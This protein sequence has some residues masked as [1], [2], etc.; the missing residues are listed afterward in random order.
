M[1]QDTKLAGVPAAVLSGSEDL[2]R[3]FLQALFTADGHVSGATNKGVSARL[4]S[5]SLAL[6]GD[7][8]RML[9]NFGIA[10]RLYANRHLARRVQLPDGR[11]GQ[12]EYECQADHDLVVARDNLARFAQE[13]GFLSS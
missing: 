1:T 4:T 8:Q 7:V 2:Q 5:V 6:L 3:G 12:A 9:L 10:S 11:G 13:I